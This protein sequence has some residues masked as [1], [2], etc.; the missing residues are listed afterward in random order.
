MKRIFQLFKIN[1]IDKQLMFLF[2]L[3]CAAVFLPMMVGSFLMSG[4]EWT[5][6]VGLIPMTALLISAATTLGTKKT[7]KIL[8][9]WPFILGI[10]GCTA[11]TYI[12][13]RMSGLFIDYSEAY[14]QKF[15]GLMLLWLAIAVGLSFV[16]SKLMGIAVNHWMTVYGGYKF[17]R[18]RVIVIFAS[19]LFFFAAMISYRNSGHVSRNIGVSYSGWLMPF[20]LLPVVV[21]AI[22]CWL[23]Q[24]AKKPLRCVVLP[25]IY[26]GLVALSIFGLSTSLLEF[27]SKLA[28]GLVF[29]SA[30]FLIGALLLR[31]TD[32]G[33]R[34]KEPDQ[35]NREATREETAHM[36][37][38]E[39]LGKSPVTRFPSF[40]GYA[41][42]LF[43]IAVCLLGLLFDA[44]TLMTW[45]DEDRWSVARAI[46]KIQSK[47]GV[48]TSS[49]AIWYLGAGILATD[50]TFA[51]NAA[52]DFFAPLNGVTDVTTHPTLRFLPS[53]VDLRPLQK[54]ALG[55]VALVNSKISRAQLSELTQ[56]T[57]L[58][59]IRCQV[60]PKG[61]LVIPAE[62]LQ[63]RWYNES[64]GQLS[65]LSNSLQL[66]GRK[67]EFSISSGMNAPFSQSDWESLVLASRNAKVKVI[68]SGDVPGHL[69]EF[70][71]RQTEDLDFVI[72]TTTRLNDGSIFSRQEWQL[73]I[74]S[75]VGIYRSVVL[76]Q[77]LNS[78]IWD[79]LFSRQSRK[80]NVQSFSESEYF[81]PNDSFRK[82]SIKFHWAVESNETADA[83][84][85]F[86]CP[87]S[88]E[89]LLQAV[90]QLTELEELSLDNDW[91]RSTSNLEED[92]A[93]VSLQ[94]NRDISGLANLTGLKRLYLPRQLNPVSLQFLKSLSGLEH[95]QIDLGNVPVAGRNPLRFSAKNCP[96]LKSVVIFGKPTNFI[97]GELAKIKTL[98]SI[99]L[100][101]K[102]LAENKLD[103]ATK[104]KTIVGSQFQMTIIHPDD[105]SPSIPDSFK[106]HFNRVREMV[107]KR[108]LGK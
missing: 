102:D 85:S 41:L 72:A 4:D 34:L 55:Q 42:G 32:S 108:Y 11:L 17:T 24:F 28:I 59:L 8:R 6:F 79:E 94:M 39:S 87:F 27:N 36:H 67:C 25:A 68:L 10:F 100:V 105:Y 90:T 70:A 98:T 18:Q 83:M 54:V 21:G 47:R 64:P 73:L 61:D 14:S 35:D 86:Y 50:S 75:Q 91:L 46:R 13:S 92:L 96:S 5:Y 60:I 78:Q 97:A 65:S 69:V 103:C 29:Y 12:L 57:F 33:Q 53:H 26:F 49:N 20:F 56:G 106:Q 22:P 23:V 45:P 2:L 31:P 66:K 93:L 51:E 99:T 88:D 76:S 107:R 80:Q 1:R 37:E 38:P 9:G 7:S 19:I 71:S 16:Y 43:A 15:D 63:F 40:W 77:E 30:F 81:D 82:Q 48:E 52:T 3:S 74:D 101:D 84:T 62:G 95:L 44:A 89:K 58:T 104:L